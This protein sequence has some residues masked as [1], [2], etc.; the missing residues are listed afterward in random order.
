M[1]DSSPVHF[2][3]QRHVEGDRLCIANRIGEGTALAEQMRSAEGG[4]RGLFEAPFR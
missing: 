2:V 3:E 4:R 1:N